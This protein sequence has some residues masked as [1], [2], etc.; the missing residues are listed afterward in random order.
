MALLFDLDGTLV[1]SAADIAAA[2]NQ[3]RVHF[4][5]EMLP[6]A[7]VVAAVGDGLGLLLDRCLPEQVSRVEASA[8][9][10]AYYSEHCVDRTACYAGVVPALQ[11]LRDAGWAMA[12]VS[13][14]PA[15]FCQRI[16]DGLGLASYLPVVIGGDGPRKPDPAPCHLALEQLGASA[17]TVHWMIG[18]NHT[19]LSAGAAMG[20]TTVFCTWG[21]GDRGGLRPDHTCTSPDAWPALMGAHAP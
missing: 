21:L 11:A 15:D 4:A 6:E 8:V 14:K 19:D 18:D 3:V 9:F 5:L 13:N 10:V 7:E 2:V 12:V 16:V 17:G 20:A 1:D